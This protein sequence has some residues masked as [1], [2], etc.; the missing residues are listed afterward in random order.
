MG[1]ALL[2]TCKDR[3]WRMDWLLVAGG[4]ISH[5]PPFFTY[6][7]F[8][9]HFFTRTSFFNDPHLYW[10]TFWYVCVG[11]Y[12]EVLWVPWNMQWACVSFNLVLVKNQEYCSLASAIIQSVWLSLSTV[13]ICDEKAKISHSDF[14]V[15]KESITLSSKLCT[16]IAPCFTCASIPQKPQFEH[17]GFS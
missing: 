12:C 13:G 14:S 2:L 7:L 3:L 1:I 16:L 17:N 6:C 9:N 10:L 15:E 5:S 11:C 4:S 8:Y